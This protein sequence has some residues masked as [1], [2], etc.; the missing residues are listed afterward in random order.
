MK[1][2]VKKEALMKNRFTRFIVV[3]AAAALITLLTSFSGYS[4]AFSDDAK[5]IIRV[6]EYGQVEGLVD[7]NGKTMAWLG[8]P[9]AKPPVGNLRWQ[10]PQAPEPWT[11]VKPT[12]DYCD[13]CSQIGGMFGMTPKGKDFNRMSETF[14]KMI[15]SEDCLYLN[16]WRP[17][18]AEQK[19]PVVVFIYGGSNILGASYDPMYIGNNLAVN[20][21]LVVVNVAYRVGHLG[22]FYHPALKTGD[23][24]ADSGNY[25]M[26]DLIQS[27]KFIKNNIANFGGDPDNVTIMGQSAGSQN[28]HGLI[29]SPLAAG[30]FHKAIPLSAGHGRWNTPEQAEGRAVALINALLI[31][32]NLATDKDSADKYRTSQSNEWMKNY[33]MSKSTADIMNVQIDP[34]GGKFGTGGYALDPGSKA[35]SLAFGARLITDGT[36]L[37]KD[38]FAAI[39]DGKFNKVPQLVGGTAEEGKLFAVTAAS[40]V[41][42]FTLFGWMVNSDPNMPGLFKLEN[43]LDTNIINQPLADNYNQY[44]YDNRNKVTP[45]PGLTTAF[46]WGL[47]DTSSKAY[48]PQVPLYVYDFRW[49][50]QPA[51][52]NVLFG[53]YH[54]GDLPFI[55]GNFNKNIACFGWSK[56]NEPGRKALSNAMQKS[57]AA[58][59]RTGD[60]NNSAL[61]TKWDPWT[62][63][64]AKKL[65]LDAT[66]TKT[67]IYMAVY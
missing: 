27:L 14:Y 54:T 38:V 31:K 26:L 45:G 4:V 53:A 46:F 61:G 13:V 12:K 32:D 22:W 65:V 55:F 28:V 43:L 11:G 8:V 18:T 56:A 30:L 3:F 42:S 2:P 57:I 35:S 9:F 40:K 24:I 39:K 20:G 51:P 59:A 36:V 16:I 60:P 29:S 49:A 41:D 44:S 25:A 6:T 1:S 67:K 5:A 21:N 19:L 37:P 58:F 62:P 50:E 64:M 34:K 47:I 17:A 15:G 48:Y 33:L 10:L 52:W 7:K 23:A 63:D 66:Y